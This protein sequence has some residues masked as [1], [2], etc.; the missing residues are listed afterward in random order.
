LGQLIRQFGPGT[1]RQVAQ[2]LRQA[3]AA[4]AAAHR[5]GLVHRDIKP[6]N[7]FLEEEASGFCAKIL[8]FGIAKPIDLDTHHTQGGTILGTPPYSAS[9]QLSG[10]QLDARSDMYS[11]AAVAY[12][13]L[14]GRGVTL[15]KTLG[16][17]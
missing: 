4:L 16:R 6:E 12:E 10:K 1:P 5:A 2:L 9:Q 11:F 15:E 3:G 13:A 8:D 14:V 17:V 7:I